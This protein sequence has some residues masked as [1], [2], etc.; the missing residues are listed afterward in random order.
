MTFANKKS[1]VKKY[2]VITKKLLALRPLCLVD[3]ILTLLVMDYFT[4]QMLIGLHTEVMLF[5][6]TKLSFVTP[7]ILD[8]SWLQKHKPHPSFRKFKICFDS[9]Y[10]FRNY[11]L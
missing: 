7:I 3:G 5:L 8:M 1:I 2:N 6:I 10:C 11:F 4:A 9:D